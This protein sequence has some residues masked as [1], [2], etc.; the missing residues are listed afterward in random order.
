[1][2]VITVARKSLVGTVAANVLRWG[3]GGVNVDDCRVE[4]SDKYSYPHGGGGSSFSVGRGPDG[5]RTK[6]V[7]SNPRGRWPANVIIEGHDDVLV[8][9]PVMH[10][11][12]GMFGIGN[13]EGNGMRYGDSGSAS[14]FFKVIP[15]E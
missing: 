1:M 12:G 4:T 11:A 2:R 8:A 6:P 15:C 5:T 10:G 14:R 7:E 13:F 3:C 9:F